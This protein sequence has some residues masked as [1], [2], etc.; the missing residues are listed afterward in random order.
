MVSRCESEVDFLI[1]SNIYHDGF[2]GPPPRYDSRSQGFIV[3]TVMFCLQ[4][5]Y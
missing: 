3:F 1:V 5:I 4:A 2:I